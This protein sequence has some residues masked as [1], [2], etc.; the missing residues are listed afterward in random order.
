MAALVMR[1]AASPLAPAES[2]AHPRYLADPR[3]SPIVAGKGGL[4]RVF[5]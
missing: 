3:V 2:F 4:K 5:L 1:F